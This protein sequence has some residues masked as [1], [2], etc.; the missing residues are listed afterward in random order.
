[1]GR[2]T[3]AR[4]LSQL[5]WAQPCAS[6]KDPRSPS[7]FASVLCD[8]GQGPALSGLLPHWPSWSLCCE[9]HGNRTTTHLLSGVPGV[10]SVLPAASRL[11]AA[12]ALLPLVFVWNRHIS[13][14]QVVPF[15][16]R[17]TN[18]FKCYCFSLMNSLRC[19]TSSQ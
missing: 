4:P 17:F 18:T 16:V 14:L 5:T 1:M 2:A 8:F 6:A 19:V 11:Q 12:H 10:S 7:G 9:L 3:L 13:F 15:L